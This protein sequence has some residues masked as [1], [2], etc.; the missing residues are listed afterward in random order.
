MVSKNNQKHIVSCGFDKQIKLWNSE[1]GAL[2][3]SFEHNT[4]NE[5]SDFIIT[6]LCISNSGRLIS[7][8]SETILNLWSTSGTLLYTWGKN[9]YFHKQVVQF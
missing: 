1:T 3:H 6:D 9:N 4:R 5:K 8:V 7:S 2:L